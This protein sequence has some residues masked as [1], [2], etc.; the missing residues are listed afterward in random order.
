MSRRKVVVIGAGHNGLTAAAMLARAGHEV[1]VLE[2][3]E[4]VGGLAARVPFGDGH[5]VPGILHDTALLRPA[6]ADVLALEQHGLRWRK[7]P[8]EIWAPRSDGSPV[9]ISGSTVSG[10]G[11]E[12]AKRWADWR[13]FIARVAPVLRDV[14]DRPPT[15]PTGQVWP[16]VRTGM[17]VR[18]LGRDDMLEL[19]RIAPM[20]VGDWLRE[21]LGDERLRA[22]VAHPALEAGFVGPWSPG[23][24]GVLL[25]REALAAE[26]VEG[27]PAALVDA[28]EAAATS[29]GATIRRAAPVAR[30]RLEARRARAV[31][32]EGGEEI[33]ADV[34]VATCDPRQT[35]LGLV[36]VRQ[37]PQRLGADVRALRMRGTTAKVHL[38]LS[39][40]LE[41]ADGT[42]LECLRTGDRLDDLERAFDPAKYRR[43]PER[44]MIEA[45]AWA[46]P[47]LCPEGHTVVS[48]MVHHAPFDLEGGW[49]DAQRE[50]LGDIAVT[51]LARHCPKVTERIVARQV[52][53]PADLASRY[54][55]SGGHLHHG[56]HAIDQ[57][58]FMRP[59]VDCARYRTPIAGLW[60]GG[61]GSHP[62]GGITCAPGALCARAILDA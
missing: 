2:A 49:N 52:L 41:L 46:S 11:E 24:A 13:A 48:L 47:D 4:D 28:L 51:E 30:I 26:E 34:V 8:L 32:L 60:L 59:T 9:R 33:A 27:G 21:A 22:A 58:L 20:A 6:L 53:S 37:L 38:A 23:T 12:E 31:V 61:S 17:R 3:R 1:V 29:H 36:G 55:L 35:F 5:A 14:M 40:P 44:P 54:R 43:L 19:L 10:C 25:L 57:L 45:R 62:G 42:A 16:L 39:G 56:E 7:Q 50:A 15:D 18:R